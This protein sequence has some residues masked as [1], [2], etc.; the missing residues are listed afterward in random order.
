VVFVKIVLPT[1]ILKLSQ[2]IIHPR[3]DE[4]LTNTEMSKS[5]TFGQFD[6]LKIQ[7]A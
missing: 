7:K 1:T 6:S 4:F 2:T 3:K 5:A